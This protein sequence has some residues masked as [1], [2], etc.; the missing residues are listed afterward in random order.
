MDGS[1]SP[2]SATGLPPPTLADLLYR[3]YP[4]LARHPSLATLMRRHRCRVCRIQLSMWR[5]SSPYLP[6]QSLD[7]VI[8]RS[9]PVAKVAG[10]PFDP[11]PSFSVAK[12][13]VGR[14]GGGGLGSGGDDSLSSPAAPS[15]WE[16]AH[17]HVREKTVGFH[18]IGKCWSPDRSLC[19]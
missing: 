5:T 6:I 13:W 11:F 8:V 7:L 4:P 3:H 2:T 12:V 9:D 10:V 16:V 14:S 1:A 18:S 19:K 15:L 17:A